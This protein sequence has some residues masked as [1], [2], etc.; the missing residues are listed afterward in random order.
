MNP[1]LPHADFLHALVCG[2]IGTDADSFGTVRGVKAAGLDLHQSLEIK[3]VGFHGDG[4]FP[5]VVWQRFELQTTW[6]Q[7]WVSLSYVHWR[8]FCICGCEKSA[9]YIHTWASAA[10]RAAKI[11]LHQF[12]SI[13]VEH[14]IERAGWGQPFF[15][16]QSSCFKQYKA[17][18]NKSFMAWLWCS[19]LCVYS[20]FL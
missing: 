19:Q 7:Q 13:W 15:G 16:L 9:R 5:A 3:R 11:F 12:L 18:V 4:A 1:A 20:N 8:M 14:K 2:N 17:R 6:K 10:A